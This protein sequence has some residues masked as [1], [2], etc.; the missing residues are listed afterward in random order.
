MSI[1]EILLIY[2]CAVNVFTFSIYGVDKQRARNN[3][4]RVPE[5][6]LLGLAVIGGGLGALWGMKCF[7]HKTRK[8]EFYIGVRVILLTEVVILVVLTL[9]GII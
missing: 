4:W 2:L 7:H 6:T 9:K 1:R 5:K 3:R 8:P